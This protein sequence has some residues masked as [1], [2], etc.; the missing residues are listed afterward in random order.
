[1][2]QFSFPIGQ[3]ILDAESRMQG[4]DIKKVVEREILKIIW[5]IRLSG[6]R[7]TNVG[8]LSLSSLCLYHAEQLEFAF[9]YGAV[10]TLLDDFVRQVLFEGRAYGWLEWSRK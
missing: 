1:M 5:G 8:S 4:K 7:E 9:L 6:A 10:V 2:I 3:N